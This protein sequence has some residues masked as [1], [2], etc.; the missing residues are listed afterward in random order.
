MSKNI[1]YQGQNLLDKTLELTGDIDNAFEMG[2]LNGISITD[3]LATGI[4]LESVEPTAPLV[5]ELF[6][7]NNRPA[8][9]LSDISGNDNQG[10][11][12]DFMEIENDF[13]VAY[14]GINFDAVEFNL[15][16]Q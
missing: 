6:H 15:I 14:D 16:V 13:I 5:V 3:D 11:G 9:A 2:L 12:I 10:Q 8:T 1:V 4:V 7:T